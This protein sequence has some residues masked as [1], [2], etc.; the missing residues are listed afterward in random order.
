MSEFEIGE[1]WFAV[2]YD[3]ETGAVVDEPGPARAEALHAG[4]VHLQLF[5]SSK[6]P[7]VTVIAS[8]EGSLTARRR[9][10]GS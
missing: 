2:E 10:P 6:L 9:R 7:K 1:S 5:S 3:G 4:V 8:R